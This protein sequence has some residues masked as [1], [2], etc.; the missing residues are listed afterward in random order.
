MHH[1]TTILTELAGCLC[2]QIHDLGLAEPCF[3]GVMPGDRV[4]LDYVGNCEDRDGMAW[5]R[6]VASYPS[7]G[8]GTLSTNVNNCG[9]AL[10]V[11]LEVGIMR[12]APKMDQS[13]EPPDEAAQLAAT[14]Q[15][16]SDMMAMYKA[17]SCCPALVDR[18]YIAGIYKP[19]GPQGYALGGT[20]PVTLGL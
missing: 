3:C 8:V 20:V 4:A 1:I 17:I 2:R 15:Q 19:M 14:D 18:E 5:V 11:D 7:T 13:G 16:I 9:S 10:S 6:L 12:T